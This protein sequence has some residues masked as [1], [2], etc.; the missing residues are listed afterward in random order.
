MS[1]IIIIII[2]DP[3]QYHASFT[4][5]RIGSIMDPSRY[6]TINPSWTHRGT[7]PYHGSIWDPS[8]LNAVPW[9]MDPSWRPEPWA[10]AIP[11][12]H[13]GPIAIPS[14][15]L[16]YVE[17]RHQDLSW[18]HHGPIAVIGLWIHLGSI[19]DPTQYYGSRM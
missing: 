15:N 19:V 2:M 12:I 18:I 8:W 3:S 10:I 5:T 17:S 6:G 14:I 16:G 1:L 13:R 7:K 11:W 9:S 4:V